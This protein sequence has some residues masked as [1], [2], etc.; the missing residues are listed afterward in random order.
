MT[1]SNLRL[2]KIVAF[3]LELALAIPFIGGTIVLSTG[4]TVL[5]VAFVVHVIVFILA[6]KL[7]GSKAGSVLGIVTSLLAWIPLVGW[8][9]HA[10]TA[11]VY[12][13][14]LLTKRE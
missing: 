9:L 12:G 6:L 7:Y 14:E 2:A 11:V 4:Y 10:I 13:I 8:A 3:I 1:M 5:G